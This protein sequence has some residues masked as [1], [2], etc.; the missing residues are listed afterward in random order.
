VA[1]AERLIV[2]NRAR[3]PKSC[4]PV[5]TEPGEIVVRGYGTAEIEARQVA[6]AV[7]RLLEAGQS[8]R[9]IA[10]LYRTG[11]VGLAMQP[12]LPPLKIPYEV[13]GAGDLWQSVAARLVVG[14]LFY[15]REGESVESMSRIGSGRRAE[16]LRSQLDQ[17]RVAGQLEFP[18]ACRLV[19]K[20]VATAVPGRASERERAE[21]VAVVDAVIALASSCRSLEGL[22]AKINQQ[23][24]SLQQAPENAVVLST[25]HS[26]KGLEW[27]AVFLIGM[28]QGVLPH[29]NNDDVEEERRVA[30]VGLTR[31]KR[32][33]GLTFTSRR[34]GQP[35]VTSQFLFEMVGTDKRR[36]VWTDPHR[37]GAD[38]HLPLLSDAERQ[39]LRARALPEPSRAPPGDRLAKAPHPR[40]GS[41]QGLGANGQVLARANN[42]QARPARHGMPWN[43]N[44]DNQLRAEFDSGQAIASIAAVHQRK[45]SA[46][47]SRLIHLGLITEDGIVRPG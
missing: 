11:T 23:S 42:P 41:S 8:P 18:A 17:A 38:E 30:Y 33:V 20:I 47:T 21:W 14:A 2:E 29:A 39:R 37:R 5:T 22:V 24:A 44:E 6:K 46:I 27:N 43:V 19:R 31:A 7:A 9:E 45:I 36:C 25:I 13:R 1:A 12:A 34:F 3:H 28:E 10:V 4:K 40:P 35:C 16:I 26:A 15:L 32:L